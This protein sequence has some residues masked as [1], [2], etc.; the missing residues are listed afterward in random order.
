M[1]DIDFFKID[2]ICRH[3]AIGYKQMGYIYPRIMTFITQDNQDEILNQ[4]GILA[5]KG[6]DENQIIEEIIPIKNDYKI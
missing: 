2:E 4:I 1:V 5:N 3:N 6:L